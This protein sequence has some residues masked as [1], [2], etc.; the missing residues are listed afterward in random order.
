MGIAHYK[1]VYTN[2][3]CEQVPGGPLGPVGPG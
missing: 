2:L 1:K 3:V